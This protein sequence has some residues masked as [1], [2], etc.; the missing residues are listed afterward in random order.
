[1]NIEI[2]NVFLFLK[3]LKAINISPLILSL[4][5]SLFSILFKTKFTINYCYLNQNIF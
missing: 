5:I 3:N 2:L 1:M 4:L